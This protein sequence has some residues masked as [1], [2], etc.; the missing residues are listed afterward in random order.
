MS[1]SAAF[2]APVLAIFVVLVEILEV[3]VAIF[4]AL[5]APVLAIFEA[6]VTVSPET[7]A[8][9][10]VGEVLCSVPSPKIMFYWS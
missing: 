8:I 2:V 1:I 3:F 9:S 4:A 10:P 5:V 7:V 6:F